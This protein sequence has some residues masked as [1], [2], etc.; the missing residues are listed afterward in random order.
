[1]KNTAN[2]TTDTWVM[3]PN[4]IVHIVHE[5]EK[6][7]VEQQ[8]ILSNTGIAPDVMSNPNVHVTFQQT[9]DFIRGLNKL[10]DR[11]GIGLYLGSRENIGTCGLMG[12]AMSCAPN[13][14]RALEIATLYLKTSPTLADISM[15]VEGQE[16]CFT[17]VPI[18]PAG[19]ILPFVIE[20][21]LS[22]T[23]R[24]FHLISGTNWTPAKVSLS[25]DDPGYKDV[26][27]STFNCPIEFGAANNTMTC[28]ASVMGFPTLQ[29]NP[30]AEAVAI[31]LCEQYLQE[32]GQVN[33][34][35]QNVRRELLSS[36][37][38][39]PNEETVSNKLQIHPRVLRRQLRLQSTSFQKIFDSVREQ[40]ALEYLQHTGMP[41]E[42]IAELVGFSDASNFRR[43]FKRW[44]NNTPSE[45]RSKLY[46]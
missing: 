21:M 14:G 9:F 28:P 40:L 43:A 26:Y 35:V 17:V 34:V 42:A 24:L 12:Y 27:K 32:H 4:K 37:G 15:S 46:G 8:D 13:V 31:K 3:S 2:T 38:K 30:V 16:L 41:I 1:M 10:T 36:P 5:M 7:G 18:V 39:F 25:Y 29:G 11:Q 23:L 22:A 20:E 19:D 33:D 45:I 6:L 44:T